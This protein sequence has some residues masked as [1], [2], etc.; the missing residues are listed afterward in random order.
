MKFFFGVFGDE[1]RF[2]DSVER[3]LRWIVFLDD[4]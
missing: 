4:F 2:K 3:S 1:G